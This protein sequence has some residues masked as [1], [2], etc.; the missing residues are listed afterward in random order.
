MRESLEDRRLVRAKLEVLIQSG[1]IDAAVAHHQSQPTPTVL[2]VE[3][4]GTSDEILTK[5]EGLAGVCDPSTSVVVIGSEND[6][7]LYRT[8]KEQGVSDYKA[9]P[10]STARMFEAIN[11]IIADPSSQVPA[12]VIG[13]VGTRGGVGNSTVAHN[14]AWCL[15]NMTGEDVMLVDLDLQFGTGALAFN[16]ETRQG[17]VDILADPDRMDL[18]VLE[19]MA[20]RYGE[21]LMVLGSPATPTASLEVSSEAVD[22]LIEMVGGLA[23][24]VVLDLPHVWMDWVLD[25]L[26]RADDVVIVAKK[27]LVCLRNT[28]NILEILKKSQAGEKPVHLVANMVGRSKGSELSVKD[29]E[30]AVGQELTASFADEPDLFGTAENNGQPVAE[31]TGRNKA[32]AGFD[33]LA[34]KLGGEKKADGQQ[35]KGA[36]D[37]LK[38]LR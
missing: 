4:S 12:H 17:V 7:E 32:R 30:S 8:L 5:L 31:G 36:L 35:K 28:Q 34:A 38:G 14:L 19:K 37:W 24:F 2:I 33:A 13:V 1:G 9:R 22:K 16:L 18:Q 15:G 11:T 3:A 10:V 20:V 6:I 21:N 25:A 26:L 29:F 23:S 27:D